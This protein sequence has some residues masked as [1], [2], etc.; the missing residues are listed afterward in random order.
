MDF[1]IWA[2]GAIV[3]AVQ[4]LFLAAIL[5]VK[6]VKQLSNMLLAVMLCL[7]SVTLIEWAFWWTGL[8]KHV[9]VLRAV[10][11]GF[12]LL[13]GPLMLLYYQSAFERPTISRQSYLHF[14]PF[15]VVVFLMLPFYLSGFKE[16]ADLLTWIP[17]ITRRPWFPALI[18]AQMITYGVLIHRRFRKYVL[19]EAALR[20]WHRLLLL[21][22][23][24]IVVT[25]IIYRL[26]P[27]LGLTAQE[28]KYLIA[29]SLTFFIY[30]VAW[31]GYIEPRIFS[32]MPLWKAVTSVKYQNSSLSREDSIQ[33]YERIVRIMEQERLYLNNELKLEQLVDKTDAPRHH[34]SQAINEQ[35]G[36]SFAEFI[37]EYRIRE[38]CQLLASSTKQE[39]NVIEVAY[40]VGF[41]SKN[42]FN[43]VF[44]KHTGMTPTAFRQSS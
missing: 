43:L 22:Y 41:N 6:K 13:Y 23:T 21:A 8:M 2:L 24:G 16:V 32:G 14:L 15:A 25:F 29:F 44:K 10:S 38:A 30:L 40:K 11:F 27:L 36:K 31:L 7:L 18:F 19:V 37:N 9:P 1:S 26:L 28:W 12:P 42:T 5:F 33:L 35:S 20:G 3:A 17:P 34:I 39:C 4:G